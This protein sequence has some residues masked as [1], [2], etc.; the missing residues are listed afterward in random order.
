[1]AVDDLIVLEGCESA[2]ALICIPN[3]EL[4]RSTTI[5]EARFAEP[6]PIDSLPGRALLVWKD[7]NAD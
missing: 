2:R 1:M 5:V 6:V 3:G 7:G 4:G